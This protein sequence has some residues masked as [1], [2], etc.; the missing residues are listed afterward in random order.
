[1][2]FRGG[3]DWLVENGIGVIDLHSGECV[4][5]LAKYIADIAKFGTKISVWTE[6]TCGAV[7]KIYA[8]RIA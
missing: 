4:R 6:G 3:I 8:R 5:M 7:R 1:V 2:N